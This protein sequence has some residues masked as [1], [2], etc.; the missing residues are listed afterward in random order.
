[1]KVKELMEQLKGYEDFVIELT[2]HRKVTDEELKNTSYPYPFENIKTEL[3]LNDIGHS[4]NVICLGCE[5]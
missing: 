5:I 3:E 1:M 2:V 4:E